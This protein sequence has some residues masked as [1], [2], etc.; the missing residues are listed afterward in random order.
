MRVM[1]IVKANKDSEAA[2]HLGLMG[3]QFGQDPPE[4]QRVLAKRW[5][6][7]VVTGGG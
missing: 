2:V 1:V 4:T 6:H 5:P 3:S 7:P